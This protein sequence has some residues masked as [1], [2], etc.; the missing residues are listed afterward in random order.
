MPVNHLAL[1]S[2]NPMTCT[3]KDPFPA[4][5][6]PGDNELK[7]NQVYLT[8]QGAQGKHA[9]NHRLVTGSG[10]TSSPALFPWPRSVLPL[11]I[12]GNSLPL[13]T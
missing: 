1:H 5:V 3:T 4:V 11:L 7:A 10:P 6:L 9:P 8:E 2:A 12:L 13:Q